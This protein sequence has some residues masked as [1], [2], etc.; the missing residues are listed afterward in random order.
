MDIF[1][2]KNIGVYVVHAPVGYETAGK[3]VIKLFAKHGIDFVFV[4]ENLLPINEEQAIQKYFVPEIREIVTRG[5][6]FCSLSHIACYE[7]LIKDEYKYAIIFEDDPCFLGDFNKDIVKIIN[8]MES[9]PESFMIS[10][11]NS[12][13]EFPPRKSL[14]K[15]KH[16]YPA[17]HGRCAGAYIIDKQ[18]AINMLESTKV[19]PAHLIIDWWHND[20]HNRGIIQHY[21]AHKPLVEQASLNG[22]AVAAKSCKKGGW[23]RRISWILQKFYKSNILRYFR[24]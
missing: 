21:W 1:K 24:N 2:E 11:E 4:N 10:L 7:Q 16:I 12:T 5:G 9:L 13:L 23:R 6:I 3:Y 22:K 8:E 20:L 14:I 19:S 17:A 18:S 15:G